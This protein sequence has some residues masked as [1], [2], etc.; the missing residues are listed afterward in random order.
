LDVVVF[1]TT[2][3]TQDGL[4]WRRQHGCCDGHGSDTFHRSSHTE[5]T[6]VLEASDRYL[7]KHRPD[8]YQQ[9]DQQ[10]SQ[11]IVFGRNYAIPPNP[12]EYIYSAFSEPQITTAQTDIIAASPRRAFTPRGSAILQQRQSSLEMQKENI[13]IGFENGDKV[14]DHY[15]LE[16][17]KHDLE[18]VTGG[19]N[20]WCLV[21]R[22]KILM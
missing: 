8:L 16:N 10:Q 3:Q 4:S 18:N 13:A 15:D 1:E 20:W 12:F 2:S 5:A 22:S 7:I 11:V 19:I 6:S 17:I 14:E 21:S 9:S